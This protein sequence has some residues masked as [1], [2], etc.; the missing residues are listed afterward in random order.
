MNIFNFDSLHDP[1]S[2]RTGINGRVAADAF[3][4]RGIFIG[5]ERAVLD[6][7]ISTDSTSMWA[8]ELLKFV[9]FCS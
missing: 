2:I 6:A 1:D 4:W 8:N 3:G 5:V 7:P 9:K